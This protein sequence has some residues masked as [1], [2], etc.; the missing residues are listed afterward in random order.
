MP[1]SKI[2]PKAC[3]I[4][5]SG[6]GTTRSEAKRDGHRNST[7][8]GSKINAFAESD[9]EANPFEFLDSLEEPDGGEGEIC[10]VE[11]YNSVVDSLGVRR[12][13]RTGRNSRFDWMDSNQP[14]TALVLTRTYSNTKSLQDTTLEIKSPYIQSAL[15][16]VVGSY[17]GVNINSTGHIIIS[18]EPR[19]LFHYRDELQ[20][21]AEDSKDPKV[22]KHVKFCL[23]YMMKALRTEIT[24]YDNMMKTGDVPPGLDYDNLWMAFKPGILL[25]KNDD[26]GDTIFRLKSMQKRDLDHAPKYWILVVES[27]KFNGEYFGYAED[28]VFISQ[29]D[30]YKPLTELTAFPLQYHQDSKALK[31][32]LISRGRKYISLA[33]IHY[34]QYD[35][36]AEIY[37]NEL[38]SPPHPYH[39]V[40]CPC[41][42]CPGSRNRSGRRHIKVRPRSRK[43]DREAYLC[44]QVNGRIVIDSDEFTHNVC[45]NYVRFK[46]GSKQLKPG[47]KELRNLNDEDLLLCHHQ[48][49]G[50]F[51]AEKKWCYFDITKVKD[52]KYNEDAFD[53]LVLPKERKEMISAL[54]RSSDQESDR[55]DDSIQGKG[56]GIIFL[57][58]GEPGVGKTYT[59]GCFGLP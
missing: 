58:Y 23:L 56:K 57:L 24:T 42:S 15:R 8:C 51:L 12:L 41:P 53:R 45:R 16:D 59:A 35:G 19:C 7:S 46:S 13:L 22:T 52:V 25:C 20:S 32:K 11:T 30:G 29:Y 44:Q 27:L 5:R 39:P 18:N 17:P 2:E 1:K 3:R 37:A 4:L 21:Y 9:T 49:P 55:F 47:S 48:M 34:C 28:T 33:G 40:G 10:E 14:K 31:K 38:L 6:T 50:F 54:V 43:R 26:G 36:A